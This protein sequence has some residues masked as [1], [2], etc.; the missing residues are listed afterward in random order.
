MAKRASSKST[1]GRNHVRDKVAQDEAKDEARRQ[2]RTDAQE[3]T[4]TAEK[5]FQRSKETRWEKL[6]QIAK[7]ATDARS[8]RRRKAREERLTRDSQCPV[9]KGPVCQ[10][11]G[12]PLDSKRH[13][14]A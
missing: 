7:A 8:Q 3:R 12:R 2:K 5:R 10:R 6:Y 1:A 11:C 4:T 13:S 14:H 9:C